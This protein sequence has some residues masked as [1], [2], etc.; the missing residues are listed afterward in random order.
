[1]KRKSQNN[2]LFSSGYTNL[3]Q[4]EQSWK[5]VDGKSIHIIG[6][7]YILLPHCYRKNFIKDMKR[8]HQ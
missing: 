3:F 8:S 1:M 2:F 6:N 4:N 7:D 5:S